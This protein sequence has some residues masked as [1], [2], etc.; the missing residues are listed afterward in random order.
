MS[1]HAPHARNEAFWN[2][3]AERYD[4]DEGPINLEN[5]YFA[6]MTRTVLE[7]YQRQ[8]AFINRSNSVYVRQHFE[9]STSVQIRQQLADLLGL[10]SDTLALTRSA[11]EGLLSLIRNYNRL[12]PGDQVLI[13]DLDYPSV[14]GAMHWLAAQRGVEVIEIALPHPASHDAL[15]AAYRQAFERYPRL[16]L[17]ALTHVTH[18]TGLVLPVREIALAAKEHGVDVI[19][20]GAH[21]L[22]LLEFDLEAL[23][24][25]FAGYN[26]QKWIGGPLSL[27]FIYIA[28]ERLADINPDMQAPHVNVADIRSR[29]PYGTP[30]IPA[31]LTL[32][33]V[34][35]EYRS[36]GGAA[37][38]G[39]RLNHLR[40]LWVTPVRQLKNIEVLTPDD[41]RLYCTIT[42]LRFR[43]HVDQQPLVDRL[44][45]DYGLFTVAREG[46]ACGPCIR[47]TPSLST[48]E[49][50][51]QRLVSALTELDALDQ[52]L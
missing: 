10:D 1:R 15:V 33:L 48:N 19:L 13:C 11:S 39:A 20:D 32:P 25:A 27:G 23:A 7:E 52:G 42:A 50:Q 46:S 47:V 28:P 24:V 37:V 22:G 51:I 16:K 30:N 41:P 31:W 17:M 26:L 21:A 40:N 18:R 45:A 34:F 2:A 12:Q 49:A 6:R 35:E 3:F 43:Q 9:R 8:I 36:L 4:A 14:Q 29:V 5:G 44:L 38:K